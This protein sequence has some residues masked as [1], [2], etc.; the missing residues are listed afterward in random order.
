MKC[1]TWVQKAG[2][3]LIALECESSKSSVLE[4]FD[5]SFHLIPVEPL[6]MKKKTY[7]TPPFHLLHPYFTLACILTVC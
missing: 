3:L 2:F 7:G 1:E 4:M 5:F 6:K